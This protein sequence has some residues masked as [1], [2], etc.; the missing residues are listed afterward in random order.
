MVLQQR[1]QRELRVIPVLLRSVSLQRTTLAELE[2]LPADKKPIAAREDRDQAFME[3]VDELSRCLG[4]PLAFPATKIEEARSAF[5][6]EIVRHAAERL[7]LAPLE[8]GSVLLRSVW[9]TPPLALDPEGREDAPPLVD[10]L[11][12]HDGPSRLAVFGQVGSGKIELLVHTAAEMAK[13]AAQD[14]SLPLPLLLH[15]RDLADG[16]ERAIQARWPL[17]AEE[18]TT[19]LGSDVRWFLLVDGLDEAGKQ[20]R[21]VLSGVATKLGRRLAR[22]VVTAGPWVRSL[23]GGAE[24]RERLEAMG[25]RAAGSVWKKT[26]LL[27]GGETAGSKMDKAGEPATMIWDEARLLA[28][29]AEHG[30][31]R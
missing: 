14:R 21:D 8:P 27:V 12:R 10:T 15:A 20:G 28:F 5:L 24:A 6:K 26:H 4:V 19:L 2:P 30:K 3:I 16:H 31:D 13:R 18:A 29:L 25:A 17:V 22:R 7:V 23:L 11:A 9:V 1:A